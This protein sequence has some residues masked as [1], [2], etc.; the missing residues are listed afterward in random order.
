MSGERIAKSTQE[1][2]VAAWIDFRNVLR[3]HE[4]A[5]KLANQAD[6]EKYKRKNEVSD[7]AQLRYCIIL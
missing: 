3:L 4:L 5:E 7:I 6:I 2:A 1:Q